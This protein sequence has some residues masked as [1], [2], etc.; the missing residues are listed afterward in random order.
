[1]LVLCMLKATKIKE[2]KFTLPWKG[3][4]LNTKKVW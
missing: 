2:C 4:F 1:M 3:F